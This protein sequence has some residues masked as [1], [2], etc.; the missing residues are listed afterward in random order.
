MAARLASLGAGSDRQLA[1]LAAIS[2]K[3][4]ISPEARVIDIQPRLGAHVF[5]AERVVLARWRGE[6]HIQLGD[7]VQIHR[8]CSLEIL[9]GGSISISAKSALERG[10]VLISL[11]EPILIESHV[12]I[13]T[14]C[15]FY[16]YD[17]GVETGRLIAEQTCTSKGPIVIKE[18]AWLG[19]G[20]AVMSGVTIG[21]GAVIG[22]GSVVTRHIP[23]NA[24]AVGIPARVVK[25]RGDEASAMKAPDRIKC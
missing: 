2:A 23:D 16:S 20:V 19:T 24:I 9:E 5:I 18:G 25:Y 4:F 22:A 13:A 11:R 10:C 15:T 7:H 1:G 6:G 3:G 12:R 17:H 8:D 21:R 14:Y